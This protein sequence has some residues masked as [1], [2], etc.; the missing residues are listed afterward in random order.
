MEPAFISS[1]EFPIHDF[2]MGTDEE[3]GERHDRDRRIGLRNPPLSIF[4]ACRG[5]DVGRSSGHIE[6]IDAPAAYPVGRSR[7]VRLADTNLS[8]AHRIDGG[9]V[10]RHSASDGLSCPL[11]KRRVNIKG[12]DEHVGVQQDHGSR[13]S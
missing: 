7:R 9:A 5:A 1:G 2:S 11:A 4:A 12:E 6:N 8:Q 10:T 13:V 3:V